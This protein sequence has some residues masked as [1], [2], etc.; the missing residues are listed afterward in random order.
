MKGWLRKEYL[1]ENVEG[2]ADEV[3]AGVF[4]DIFE[5][6]FEDHGA[7][8]VAVF[9]GAAGIVSFVKQ[10]VR[11]GKVSRG[12]RPDG[13]YKLGDFLRGYFSKPNDE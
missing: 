10:N 2:S 3:V 9:A 12:E 4:K 6:V 11:K 7:A 8:K 13:K 1:L 5:K